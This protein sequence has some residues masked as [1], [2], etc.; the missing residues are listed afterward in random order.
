MTCQDGCRHGCAHNCT[1]SSLKLEVAACAA[2]LIVEEGLEYGSAK[3]RALQMLN[4]PRARGVQPTN[5]EVEVAVREHLLLFCG[6]T[7]PNEIAAMRGLALEWME[8]MNAFRP[9]LTGSVWR[10]TATRHADIYIQLFCDDSKSAEIALI[11]QGVPFEPRSTIGMHGEAVDALS[12]S[13]HCEPIGEAIGIHLI[14]YDHDD[15]RGA[16]KADAS[17]RAPRGDAAALRRLM[18]ASPVKSS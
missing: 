8:R 13:C 1:M 2:R 17:G 14:V 6:H 4:I 3:R 9:Y 15:L 11:D 10:G 5:D 16:L 12:F 7:Q 18:Q